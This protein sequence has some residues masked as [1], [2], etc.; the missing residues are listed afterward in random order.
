MKKILKK[1]WA[2]SVVALI[3]T[4]LNT[5]EALELDWTGQFWS[6][7]NY[8]GNYSSDTG[9]T[10]DARSSAG[11]YFIP[12]G[13]RSDATFQTLF[14]RLRPKAIINDNISIK[15]EWWVLDPIFGLYGSGLPYTT[16]QNNFYSSQNRGSAINAQRIWGEFVSDLGTFQVGRVPLHWGLG[17]VWNGGDNLWDRYMST[18]DA[19]RWI[20]KFGSF[21]VA[22]SYI[23][24]TAGNSIGGTGGVTDFSLILKYENQEDEVE[25]GINLLKQLGGAGQSVTGVGQSAIGAVFSPGGADRSSNSINTWTYDIYARK[26]FKE[27][28]FGIEV[29]ISSG[30][31]SGA[32]YSALGVAAEMD[33]KPSD[34]LSF[35]LKAGY[36]SGQSGS[37][38]L[39]PDSFQAFYFNPNYHVGMIMFNYQLA[40]FAGSQTL[41][42]PTN[43]LRS[44]YDNPIVNAVYGSLSA[45]IKPSDKWTFRPALIYAYAP[46]TA[47]SSD[48]YFYN[49]W[50]RTTYAGAVGAKNQGSGLGVEADLGFTFQWDEYFTFG[51]DTGLYFPGDFFKFSNV[52]GADLPVHPIFASA[53]KVGVNF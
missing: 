50:S 22:P 6:E 51:L 28:S 52:A 44:P 4:H 24:R 42:N 41:N 1:C 16:D 53:L 33:W 12:Q 34:S 9:G 35:L 46:N 10:G 30:S 13:G 21:T 37:K 32:T 38:S 49:Y 20:A 47:K 43:L 17:L 14:L 31:I 2:L 27:M 48:P 15:S 3:C 40:N 25:A 18:G 29:P 7:F 19:V 45:Q 26:R 8:V 36:A 5:A 11:G 39:N 23:I